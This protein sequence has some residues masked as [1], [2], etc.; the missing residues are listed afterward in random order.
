MVWLVAACDAVGVPEITP[1]PVFKL[2]PA[3]KAGLML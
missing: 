2:K 1:V 3:G